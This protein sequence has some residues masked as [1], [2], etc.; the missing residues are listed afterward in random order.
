MRSIYCYDGKGDIIM[1]GRRSRLLFF[2]PTMLFIFVLVFSLQAGAKDIIVDPTGAGDYTTIQDAIDHAN[3]GDTIWVRNGSYNEQLHV[4]VHD[5]TIVAEEGAN[6]KIYVTSYSP[7]IDVNASNV[8]I[9]GFTIYG[10]VEPDGPT[11]RASSGA[12]NLRLIMNHFT[13]IVG[14]RGST[15]L[16]VEEGVKK[17]SFLSNTVTRY[18]ISVFLEN[19]SFVIISGN[20]MSFVNYS[21]YHAASIEGTSMYYG[22]IEDAINDAPVGGTVI[23]HDGI[24]RQQIVINKPVTLEGTG[25]HLLDFSPFNASTKTIVDEQGVHNEIAGIYVNASNVTIKNLHFMGIPYDPSDPFGKLNAV[26]RAYSTASDLTVES[27]TFDSPPTGIARAALAAAWA[28]RIEFSNN[29]I[30]N[31]T[32]G[33]YFFNSSNPI[34]DSMIANND[35]YQGKYM[36]A[37]M[38]GVS[39]DICIGVFIEYGNNITLKDNF[40]N[41]PGKDTGTGNAQYTFAIMVKSNTSGY[42]VKIDHDTITNYSCGISIYGEGSLTKLKVWNNSIGMYIG[43][44]TGNLLLNRSR[45]FLN[46]RAIVIENTSGHI[47]SLN[48]NSIYNNSKFGMINNDSRA[49]NAT[50]NWWGD[51]MGPYNESAN[52]EGNGDNITGNITFWPWLEFDGYSIPPVVE[53]VVGDPKSPDG[54]V[55]SDR[56]KIEIIAHD[57]ESGM[58]VVKYR[59]WDTVNRWS[60]W[61]NYTGPFTLEGEGIHK[62][63]YKAIDKAGTTLMGLEIHRVDTRPADVEVIYPNGG[64]YLYGTVKIRWHAADK[65]L[66]QEQTE[67]NDSVPLSE[68]YPGHIQSFVP[69]STEMRSVELLLQGDEANVTVMIFSSIF[70][71]PTPIAKS[72]RHLKDITNPRW[73]EF[74]FKENI[75]LVPNQTYYI[76]VTQKVYGE[77]GFRWYY[78]NVS[79]YNYGHAWLKEVDNLTSKPNWDWTFRTLYWLTDLRITVQCSMTGTSPWTT[80]A[81]NETNDGEF[82]WNT[83]DFPDA[84][85]YKVRILAHDAIN[86]VGSDESDDNFAIDNVGP[87]IRNIIIRDQTVGSTEFTKDGDTIEISATITGDP[88]YIYANLTSLGKGDEVPPTSYTA[89]VAKWLVPSIT[90]HPSNGPVTITITAIDA[91]GNRSSAKASI[92]ADN[93]PPDIIITKPR[94]GVYILDSMRLLPWPYPFVIGQITLTANATDTGSGIKEV[95][96]YIDNNLKATVTEPPYS[97]LWDELSTGFYKIKAEAYDVVGHKA[98]AEM[99]DVFIINLDIID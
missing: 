11:V 19:H 61:T 2:I 56:T 90:C 13:A 42:A 93:L 35:F 82:F 79:I 43:Q 29:M 10:S 59:I 41:G 71:V 66:D 64:E 87:S 70:P 37:S 84:E 15:A 21:V 76:G 65:V 67:W 17:V 48:Y 44:A 69:T 3:P 7:G 26:I 9:E 92:I 32:Y 53:Y 78:A 88:E 97:W 23:V 45:F 81:E 49:V 46:D 34:N 86:N 57:N 14:E 50:Y 30:T 94:P 91:T 8:T 95:K 1:E 52:P 62:V 18:N 75:E 54:Y 36:T 60:D 96:F 12:D 51:V 47:L 58:L 39:H 73:I 16:L 99:P 68:D 22:S 63:Q 5:L 74:P 20:A 31:Y 4:Y 89:N 38:G 55:V 98:V 77:T 27:N 33:V 25:D 85:T 80:L 28:D 40:F 83:R 24:Y 72:T 6:P